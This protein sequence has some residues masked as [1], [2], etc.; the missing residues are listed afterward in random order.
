VPQVTQRG[1]QLRRARQATFNL[2]TIVRNYTEEFGRWSQNRTEIFRRGDP[3]ISLA[4][5]P[6]AGGHGP[7]RGN[8]R[9]PGLCRLCERAPSGAEANR[10]GSSTPRLFFAALCALCAS[11]RLIAF[12]A[13]SRILCALCALCA[14]CAKSG[15]TVSPFGCRWRGARAKTIDE[16]TGRI[17]VLDRAG[18]LGRDGLYST[19]RGRRVG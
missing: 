15:R 2:N 3:R 10:I 17:A 5:T 4:A 6:F 18:I 8:Y 19:A 16:M 11:M 9:R 7:S 13:L 14:P 12:Y 1:D